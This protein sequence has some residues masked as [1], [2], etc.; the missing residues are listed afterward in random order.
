MSLN[1]VT[2]PQFDTYCTYFSHAQHASGV[3]LDYSLLHEFHLSR[4]NGF[5]QLGQGVYSD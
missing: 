3:P 1:F 2:K 5:Q 4:Q